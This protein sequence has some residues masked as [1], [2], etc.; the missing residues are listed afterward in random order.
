LFTSL[1]DCARP[2]AFDAQTAAARVSMGLK[3]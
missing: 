3:P 2:D 1:K